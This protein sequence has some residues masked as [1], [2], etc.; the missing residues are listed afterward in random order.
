LRED[1][2]QQRLMLDRPVLRTLRIECDD[3]ESVMDDAMVRRLTPM[4]RD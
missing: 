2:F 3:D 1:E 4:M